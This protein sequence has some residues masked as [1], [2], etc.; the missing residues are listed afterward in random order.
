MKLKSIKLND[1]FRSLKKGF[2]LNFLESSFG[3]DKFEPYAIVGRNGSGKSNILELLGSIFYNLELRCLNFLPDIFEDEKI[4]KPQ[5]QSPNAY[6][7][8]YFINSSHIVIKKEKNE[9]AKITKDDEEISSKDELKEVL[10]EYVIGYSSGDNEIL[11][12]PFFKMRFIQYDE[13]LN[14]L[15]NDINYSS[16]EAR[17]IYLDNIFSQA[18]FLTNFLLSDE[19]IVKVFEDDLGIK[20]VKQFRIILKQNHFESMSDEYLYTTDEKVETE[21]TS[22]L[23]SKIDFLISCSTLHYKDEASG[24]LIMDFCVDDELKKAFRLFFGSRLELFKLFQTLI[25]LNQYKADDE[26]KDK[27]YK[28]NSLYAKARIPVLPWE[29][30]IFKFKDFWIDKD[31]HRILSKSL[32]DGEYQFLHTIGLALLYKNTSSLFLLD[33]PETHFNPAWR[34]KYISTLKKCFKSDNISPEVLITSHSPFIVS[35]SKEENVLVFE[36]DKQNKVTC[37]RPDFNTFGASINKITIK[38]FEKSET[39]GDMAK[40]KL[41]EFKQRIENEDNIDKLI[42]EVEHTLGDSVEKILLLKELFDKQEGK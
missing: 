37:K 5:N 21:L 25:L 36:R 22:G 7:L 32:S 41:E 17:L 12:L 33:E 24:E 15:T 30:R 27:I 29:D 16:P 35:D 40:A 1:D 31:E 26:L 34:A 14:Y 18:I 10:P 42:D 6:E 9:Y 19:D 8:E 2:E 20:S 38:V 4:S 11:S 13:Y 3:G 39:I 28:S 23:Q